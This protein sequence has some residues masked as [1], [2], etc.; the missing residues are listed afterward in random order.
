MKAFVL[1]LAVACALAEITVEDGVLVLTNDNFDAAISEHEIV[2]V[3]FC[4]FLFDVCFC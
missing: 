1:L 2:L 4:K 3:E